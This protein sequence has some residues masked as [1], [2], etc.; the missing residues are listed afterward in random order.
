MAVAQRMDSRKPKN[1]CPPLVISVHGIRT[2]GAWQKTFAT[3]MS[4]SPAKIESFDYGKYGLIRFLMPASND[5]LVN[6][7]YDWFGTVTRNAANV[8]LDRYD[9]RPSV[10]AH[11]LGSWIVGNA[12]L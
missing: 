3:A 2:H 6:R 9:R 1:Y 11:S 12:M 5:R 10:V 4:G 7:F 8:D